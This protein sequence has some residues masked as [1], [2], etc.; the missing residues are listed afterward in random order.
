MAHKGKAGSSSAETNMSTNSIMQYIMHTHDMYDELC[1][2]NLRERE[3]TLSVETQAKLK[4]LAGLKKQY[5]LSGERHKASL[6]QKEADELKDKCKWEQDDIEMC[7]GGLQ[8]SRNKRKIILQWKTGGEDINRSPNPFIVKNS[9]AE[10]VFNL[11]WETLQKVYPKPEL[12]A[13]QSQ[14]GSNRCKDKIIKQVLRQ[15]GLQKI[16]KRNQNIQ[17]RLEDEQHY[18]SLRVAEEV[19]Q[20]LMRKSEETLNKL[21]CLRIS[22]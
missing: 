19:F 16:K 18:F 21:R 9:T 14:T 8:M 10:H 1:E 5:E 11:T 3:K 22:Q 7:L 12:Q 2:S 13:A 6:V 15:C 17:E 20:N 4:E